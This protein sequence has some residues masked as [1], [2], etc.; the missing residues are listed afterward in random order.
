MTW[1]YADE[2]RDAGGGGDVVGRSSLGVPLLVAAGTQFPLRRTVSARTLERP[3]RQALEEQPC[4]QRLR[5]QVRRG[6]VQVP[7]VN[8]KKTAASFEDL[9]QTGRVVV[10]LLSITLTVDLDV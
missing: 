7:L 9:G 5:R 3:R 8:S 2:Q 6:T 10:Q 4:R 1:V